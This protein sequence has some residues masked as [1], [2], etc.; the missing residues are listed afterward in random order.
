MM[1]TTSYSS[2]AFLIEGGATLKGRVRVSGAKNASLP[3]IFSTILTK[4]TCV[5]EDVPDLLDVKNACELIHLLGAEGDRLNGRV[6]IDPSGIDRYETPESIVKKMRASVLSMG[7]LLARFGRARVAL[8]GGCSIGARPI[9]QHLKF[10][11]SAGAQVLVKDG[12]VNIEVER[13]K[14]AEF[15][16]ELV[17]VTGT[18]NALLYLS[19]VE[20]RSILKNIALEPEVIDL[21]EVLRKMGASI[22]IEGRTAVVEG[23]EELK[24]FHHRV[25]PDRIEAG[26]LMV[27]SLLTGGEV[28]LE[29]VL[30]EHLGA[31][32]GKLEEAGAR[33]ERLGADRLRVV[34][35]GELKP[36]EIITEEYPGFPTDMQAQF[37][38]MLSVTEGR[39]MIYESIFENRFQHVYEL[40]KMGANI[41]VRGRSAHIEGVRELTGAEVISTDLRASASLVLAGLV[42][43]GTTVIRDIHH[44]DRGYERL[45][46]KLRELGASVERL[47]SL[48]S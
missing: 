32:I 24:G 16:F 46:K 39:S 4:E 9:D 43:R 36:L 30:P 40:K 29:N 33:V 31:V 25:I 45:E 22:E 1:N 19:G 13:K 10:F 8:P 3:I 44:L 2:D 23:S 26:T 35:V 38:V 28:E 27:A 48:V 21:V 15:E 34:K 12:Y 37:M 18:E 6:L 11:V 5:I 20:G 41:E 47:P 17:T 42:A 7:P 14:P